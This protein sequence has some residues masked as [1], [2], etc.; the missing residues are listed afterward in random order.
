MKYEQSPVVIIRLTGIDKLV[1]IQN[2]LKEEVDLTVKDKQQ[3]E[4]PY[5][6]AQ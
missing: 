4:K 1:L 3:Q 2:E 6:L 5:K